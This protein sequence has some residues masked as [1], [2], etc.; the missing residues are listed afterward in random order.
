MGL[1]TDPVEL[2]AFIMSALWVVQSAWVT[3]TT[4]SIWRSTDRTIPRHIRG[5]AFRRL[6]LN[7][8][9]F[10]WATVALL[11]CSVTLF[12]PVGQW[13]SGVR[14]MAVAVNSVFGLFRAF[15]GY[16]DQRAADHGWDGEERRDTTN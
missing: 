9:L 15:L 16:L 13:Q 12:M 14:N 4:W 5:I 8:F 11:A 1:Y 7:I 2:A 3:R 6:R 10:A